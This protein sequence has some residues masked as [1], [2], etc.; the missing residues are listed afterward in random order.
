MDSNDHRACEI[1]YRALLARLE[2]MSEQIERLERDQRRIVDLLRDF[3]ELVRLV[4]GRIKAS[5]QR[6]EDLVTRLI[7]FHGRSSERIARHFRN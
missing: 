2:D 6:I 4:V 3:R 7:P 5:D 1:R